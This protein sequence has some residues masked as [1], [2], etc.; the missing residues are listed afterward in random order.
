R[1]VRTPR[2]VSCASSAMSISSLSARGMDGAS[3]GGE[4]GTAGGEMVSADLAHLPAAGPLF[5]GAFDLRRVGEGGA[6]ACPE[7][8]D[9]TAPR[10]TQ[11]GGWR[12]PQ[13][14]GQAAGVNDLRHAMPPSRESGSAI[15]HRRISGCGDSW[16][17][18]WVTVGR[19]GV[20]LDAIT[21]AWLACHA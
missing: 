9:P 19:C 5:G 10:P 13:P 16:A 2:L 7:A 21:T 11:D 18:Q 14:F 8:G 20:L 6:A 1:S 12:D 15:W 17:K 3:A 4:E